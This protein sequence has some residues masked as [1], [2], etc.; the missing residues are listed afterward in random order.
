[1]VQRNKV[2]NLG[3]FLLQNEFCR[4]VLSGVSITLVNFVL[5]FLFLQFNWL[6]QTANLIAIVFA[7]VYGFF[8][9]KYFVYRS[10]STA[11]LF[12][13]I[14]RYVLVRGSTGILDYF[15][16]LFLVEFVTFTP[17]MAKIVTL[18]V[19]IILNYIL[20]RTFVFVRGK[21]EKA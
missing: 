6:Y 5:F 3:K 11:S 16:V 7:K 9:N 17:L 2:Y 18:V 21:N 1:M 12:S 15:A 14:W 20:G 4:F 10:I 19:V 13:E 8:I